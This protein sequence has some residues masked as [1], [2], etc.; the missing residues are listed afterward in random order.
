MVEL[1]FEAGK[2]FAAFVLNDLPLGETSVMEHTLLMW[3]Q[4]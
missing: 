2:F 4:I 3:L 1:L